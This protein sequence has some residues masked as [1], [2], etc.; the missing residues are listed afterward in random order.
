MNLRHLSS[1]V[2]V[3][4]KRNP[5]CTDYH[6]QIGL[7]QFWYRN[8]N[9]KNNVTNY[10]KQICH[11]TIYFLRSNNWPNYIDCC[12]R[13]STRGCVKLNSFYSGDLKSRLVWISNGQ[14]EVGF[15]MVRILNGIWNLEAP[16]FEIQTNGRQFVNKY[17][18]S[19][20]NRSYFELSVF[21]MVGTIA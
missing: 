13:R 1:H 10:N 2:L 3:V 4:L 15:Q 16:A 7:V 21:W 14:K 5:L 9:I 17:L 19:G 18:K 11:T 6:S 20:Q 8:F 12:L